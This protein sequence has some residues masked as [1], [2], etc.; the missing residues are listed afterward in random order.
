MAT[1]EDRRSVK[2]RARAQEGE[3]VLTAAA[4]YHVGQL[5]LGVAEGRGAEQPYRNVAASWSKAISQAA[6]EAEQQLGR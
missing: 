6:D 2:V 4:A 1:P 5:L 3:V